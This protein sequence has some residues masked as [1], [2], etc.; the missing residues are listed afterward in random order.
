MFF[1]CVIFT[2][3]YYILYTISYILY[4]LLLYRTIEYLVIWFKHQYLFINWSIV[5]YNF[6]SFFLY[7]CFRSLLYV[8]KT[9]PNKTKYIFTYIIFI[10]I[11]G[12]HMENSFIFPTKNQKPKLLTN[13][14][15][16]F[17]N[18]K[19]SKQNKNL[20]SKTNLSFSIWRSLWT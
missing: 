19:K 17:Q 13:Y 6:L 3:V 5:F 12:A 14:F 1:Y 18:D 20:K 4:N 7:F 8:T 16:H 15:R 9:K 10:Y 11:F 2:I